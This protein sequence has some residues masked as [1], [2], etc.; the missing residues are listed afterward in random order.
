MAIRIG[1]HHVYRAGGVRRGGGRQTRAAD[2]A[3]ARC[4]GAAETDRGARH[5]I[6]TGYGDGC[7]TA[8]GAAAGCH[9]GDGGWWQ[10]GGVGKPVGKCCALAIGIGDHHVYRTGG[11]CRGC[12]RQSRAADNAGPGRGGT[13]EADRGA[14]HEIGPGQGHDCPAARRAAAGGHHGDAGGGKSEGIDETVG[15]CC[16]LLI[17]I[18]DHHVY[19]T[20]DM[21]RGSGRQ[22]RATDEADAG[23]GGTTEADRSA[24]HEIS[25]G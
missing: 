16:A 22:T 9:R 11:V 19:R 20:G 5:E 15:E 4:S 6:G 12:G 25:P 2:K 7:P 1:D 23:C 21:S 18:G 8:S 17:G 10:G 24:R 14:R 13:A 3:D